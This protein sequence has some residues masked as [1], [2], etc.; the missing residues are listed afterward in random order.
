M[1]VAHS[2]RETRKSAIASL[3]LGVTLWGTVWFPYRL[4]FQAGLSPVVASILTDI[5]ALA[6][7]C[8]IWRNALGFRQRWLPLLFIA[9][10]SGGAN[11]GYVIGTVYGEVMRVML[12]FY[13][14][15]LWTVL[16]AWLLLGERSGRAGAGVLVLSL[17]GAVVMLWRPQIGMPWPS[18]PAD[19]V[20]LGAGLLFA[21]SNVLVRR[22]GDIDNGMKSLS[23]FFG[24]IVVGL[25]LLPFD[26]TPLENVVG[27]DAPTLLITLATGLA[28]VAATRVV[29]FGIT[30]LPANRA[31]VIML[32]ELVIAALAA[33]WLA[34]ESMTARE[35]V[36]GALIVAASLLSGQLEPGS[37]DPTTTDAGDSSAKTAR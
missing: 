22:D 16:W 36:G 14:A 10:T 6:I 5:V 12:L 37:A 2:D 8:V 24:V 35:W 27:I 1:A 28:L 33:W 19:W 13:L 9:L 29:Y 4:L 32:F 26:P 31:I 7:G 21:L 3:L 23:A 18:S 15:P 17:S 34:G 20:G 25:A 30:H 11:V